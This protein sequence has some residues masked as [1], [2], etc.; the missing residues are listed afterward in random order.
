MVSRNCFLGPALNWLLPSHFVLKELLDWNTH[1]TQAVHF[2]TYHF[3]ESFFSL[4]LVICIHAGIL[5]S[6]TW[7]GC[8]AA[9]SCKSSHH[10]TLEDIPWPAALKLFWNLSPCLHILLLHV[11]SHLLFSLIPSL[12][13]VTVSDL[14][15]F[16]PSGKLWSF[17]S[18]NSSSSVSVYASG[19]P[20]L[21]ILS[22]TY[23]A[24]AVLDSPCSFC[25]DCMQWDSDSNGEFKTPAFIVIYLS[26]CFYRKH[27]FLARL[28]RKQIFLLDLGA[29]HASAGTL[30]L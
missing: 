28:L 14:C 13:C 10:S 5:L 30:S 20:Y 9:S 3:I 4:L 15:S 2:S 8:C 24:I 29:P 21:L 17:W 16:Q 12:F 7:A 6:L 25:N 22:A 19:L 1:S 23:Q 27:I 26:H 18:H 11:W